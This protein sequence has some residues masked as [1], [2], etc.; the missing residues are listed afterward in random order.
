MG[1]EQNHLAE[2]EGVTWSTG[3]SG[4]PGAS[5]HGG[6]WVQRWKLFHGAFREAV[7]E[8]LIRGKREKG[9]GEVE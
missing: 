9:G 3:S 7:E 4:A 2:E 5:G 8:E 6:K 1:S